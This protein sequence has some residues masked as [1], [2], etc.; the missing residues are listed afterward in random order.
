VQKT[1]RFLCPTSIGN[2]KQKRCCDA[3]MKKMQDFFIKSQNSQVHFFCAL[4]LMCGLSLAV[5]A[6]ISLPWGGMVAASCRWDCFWYQ[7]IVQNGYAVLPR[8]YDDFRPAQA[9]WAFFPL[10]PLLTILTQ[11]LLHLGS[12]AAGLLINILLWPL[13]IVLCWVDLSLRKVEVNKIYFALFFIIYPFNIWYYAQYSEAI[14]GV[15]LMAAVVFLRKDRPGATSL[16]CAF[17]AAAR[18]T[19]FIMGACLAAWSLLYGTENPA[20][21]NGSSVRN[22]VTN[23]LLILASSGAG[24]SV[25]VLYLFHIMGD[26]FAFAHVEVAWGKEFHFFVYNIIHSF[27]LRG[28]LSSI[29]CIAIIFT[30]WK[31][32]RP[33][34]GLNL[35]LSGVTAVLS[36]SA[37]L[38]SIERYFFGNPLVIQFLAYVVLSQRA[39]VRLGILGVLAVL[40]IAASFLWYSN[41]GWLL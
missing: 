32:Y 34:W 19:G 14:Y 2:K 36:M 13:L 21:P 11:K 20:A 40:R 31:M 30:L 37:G 29:Y 33:G 38:V 27:A 12:P 9:S 24:L 15:L 6:I 23:S 35:L 8:L 1:C 3:Q 4:V 10:Y 17:M 26:G 5:Q 28:H 7:D 16:L 22:R 41:S 18:P 39:P 25:Y